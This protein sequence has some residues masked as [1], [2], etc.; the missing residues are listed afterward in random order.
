MKIKFLFVIAFVAISLLSPTKS[1]SAAWVFDYPVCT[2][3]VS[4]RNSIFDTGNVSSYGQHY[5]I[6]N[7][8]AIPTTQSGNGSVSL[9][10]G[11]STHCIRI[12][13]NATVY[14]ATSSNEV[15]V[16]RYVHWEGGGSHGTVNCQYVETEHEDSHTDYYASPWN[17]IWAV[18]VLPGIGA[19]S[20]SSSGYHTY[21]PSAITLGDGVDSETT[22][23]VILDG[24]HTVDFSYIGSYPFN[25]DQ[26][27]PKI[28][29]AL[30][31]TITEN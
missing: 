28:Q 16:S 31:T 27:I 2:E 7:A 15:S 23:M 20:F 29:Y 10:E 6:Y 14:T 24:A 17:T 22:T 19:H 9:V 1:A 8:N 21:S 12:D 26:S 3:N 30:Q 18:F 25:R 5:S 13:T 4:N 11:G